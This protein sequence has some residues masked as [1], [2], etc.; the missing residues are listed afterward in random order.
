M[1]IIYIYLDRQIEIL[2]NE[3]PL[4]PFSTREVFAQKNNEWI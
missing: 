1:N 3:S 2:K 4:N